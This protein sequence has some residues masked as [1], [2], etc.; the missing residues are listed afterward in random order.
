MNQAFRDLLTARVAGAV[1]SAKALG[2]V[3]HAGL[4]GALR[5]VLIRSLL[6]P[7]LPPS[8]GV[9]HGIIITAYDQQSP[10]QD[11]VIFSRDMTPC[12]LIDEETGLFP[13]ESVISGIEVKS[14]LTAE[15]LR[16]TH[17]NAKEIERLLHV[18]GTKS[19]EHIIPCLL[20]FDSD[21]SKKNELDRYRGVL[22]QN[23][24]PSIRVI[25]VVGCGYWYWNKDGW[26]GGVSNSPYSEVASLIDGIMFAYQRISDSRTRPKIQHYIE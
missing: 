17:I 8:L 16:K 25:C 2:K 15:E 23:E 20:A 3:N 1:A 6:R 19:P 21:L 5:E 9:G 22:T 18:P 7:L 10:E 11:A 4:K 13:L 12:L 14:V 24:E 26:H